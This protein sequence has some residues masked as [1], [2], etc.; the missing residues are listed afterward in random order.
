MVNHANPPQLALRNNMN[1]FS[2]SEMSDYCPNIILSQDKK[3]NQTKIYCQIITLILGFPN[4]RID[5]LQLFLIHLALVCFN[6]K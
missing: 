5:D 6:Y 3:T 4:E 1:T 2:F